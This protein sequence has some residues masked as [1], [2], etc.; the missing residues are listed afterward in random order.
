MHHKGNKPLFVISALTLSI[1]ILGFFLAY[2]TLDE[3][4][5]AL[6]GSS[7][8]DESSGIA[9]IPSV[10]QPAISAGSKQRP[11]DLE[12]KTLVPFLL[13]EEIR[14][15]DYLISAANVKT[16]D[17]IGTYTSPETFNG[18]TADYLY[19]IIQLTIKNTGQKETYAPPDMFFLSDGT[20]E[21]APHQEA[22]KY[23]FE[24]SIFYPVLRTGLKRTVKIA[25][26]VPDGSYT[27]HI[28]DGKTI[29]QMK[30]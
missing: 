9:D 11:F 29:Y 10:E 30:I 21:Y 16:T 27:F 17:R 19:T 4:H 2:L 18:R 15:G 7:V 25:Y 28:Y 1:A 13:Q 12:G 22:T 5:S 3:P 26:D 8:I 24:S 23:L 14:V 20:Y 6:T